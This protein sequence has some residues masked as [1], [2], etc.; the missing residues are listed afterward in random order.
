MNKS[1][2]IY[3]NIATICLVN[4]VFTYFLM[5]P[6]LG[7]I[8]DRSF[9]EAMFILNAFF[10]HFALLNVIVFLLCI[11]LSQIIRNTDYG[12]Y[13]SIF[14][15]VLLDILLYVDLKIFQ[16]FKFHINGMIINLLTSE[17]A[18][19]SVNIGLSTIIVPLFALLSLIYLHV[20]SSS[21]F[22][23]F[24]KQRTKN[25]KSK[26]FRYFFLITF[27]LVLFDK[28]VYA[29]SDLTNNIEFIRNRKTF[30]LYQPLTVKRA[31]KKHFDYKIE[32]ND[33]INIKIENSTLNYPLNSI[34]SDRPD[35]L[36][37]Y[38]LVVLDSWRF[39]MLSDSITPNLQK[40]REKFSVFENHY[41]GGNATRFGIF[42]LFYGIYGP[43]WHQFQ[44]E[45][46]SPVMMDLLQDQ[47]Y[48]MRISSSTSLSWP[49]F[50]RTAFINVK[51]SIYDSYP[52]ENRALRDSAQVADFMG[53]LDS[54]SKNPFFSFLFLDAPHAPY[55]YPEN[56]GK[57]KP[58]FESINFLNLNQANIHLA[59]NRYKSAIHYDDKLLGK[60]LKKFFSSELQKNTVLIITG[61]HGEEFFDISGFGH[62]GN[63][64][65]YRTKVPFLMYHP[66]NERFTTKKLSSHLD[67]VPTIMKM[68]N[69]TNPT[70]DYSMGMDLYNLKKRDF[71]LTSGWNDCA[72]IDENYY[73]VFPVQTYNLKEIEIRNKKYQFV[74]NY[75]EVFSK[76]NKDLIEISKDLAR[77]FK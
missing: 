13:L 29:Y 36:Y 77:F 24:L 16:I 5:L 60:L 7:I 62:T 33:N 50:R 65:E 56:E 27:I 12:R 25:Y 35:S 26:I 44:D 43:Y 66:K 57:F 42:S 69:V 34:S 23:N 28:S 4:L 41:S 22:S 75:K 17:G 68:Q 21:S 40:H 30:F 74:K 52:Q 14:L 1:R 64:T 37:N 19:D 76:K 46:R 45:R 38:I 2:L 39:D 18:A 61:D 73:I 8:F 32:E 49:E 55:Y 9:S 47:G 20:I 67:L 54:D 53:F 51:D 48:Q 31:M 58:A 6:L 70:S 63:F 11:T 72:Y 3:Y 15:F 71:I 10:S 59:K